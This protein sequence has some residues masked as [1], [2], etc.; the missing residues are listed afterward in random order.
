MEELV[1][2]ELSP[3]Q[4]RFWSLQRRTGH[5]FAQ[6]AL[7]VQGKPDC[8]LLSEA[9]RRAVNQDAIFR[10]AYVSIS[11]TE[12]PLQSINE[13]AVVELLECEL[14]SPAELDA[15][16]QPW[17]RV[18]LDSRGGP[19]L[20]VV[21]ASLADGQTALFLSTPSVCADLRSLGV[22]AARIAEHYKALSAGEGRPAFDNLPYLQFSEWQNR[23]IESEDGEEGKSYWLT[24]QVESPGAP[25]L[26]FDLDPNYVA[27][28]KPA[29][30]E[31]RLEGARVEQL[32]GA[33]RATESTVEEFLALS[34]LVLLRH[35][36]GKA[37]LT[38]GHVN[39]FRDFEELDDT[40][41]LLSRCLP[42]TVPLSGQSSFRECLSLYRRSLDEREE[43]KFFLPP[44]D[45]LPQKEARGSLYYA[46]ECADGEPRY[47]AA[48]VTFIP[49][50]RRSLTETH[51]L[52]LCCLTYPERIACE[53]QYHEPSFSRDAVD[54]LARA[55]RSVLAQCCAD[56]DAA[57]DDLEL[58]DEHYTHRLLHVFNDT[59]R[60]FA[61]GH[62]TVG[63][64]FEDQAASFPER[65]ALVCS[66]RSFAYRELNER[67][68]GLAAYL[69]ER[70]G[71][72][73]GDLL[74]LM[75][76]E[77]ERLVIGMLGIIKA[78]GAYVPLD[79]NNPGERIGLIIEDSRAKVI[80]TESDLRP[81]LAGYEGEVVALDEAEF[82]PRPKSGEAFAGTPN[83]TSYVIYTSGTTGRPKGVLI[84][85]RSLVNYACWLRHTFSFGPADSSVL[86]SSYA[87]D[88]G[89]TSIW[90]MLL[91]GGCLHLVPADMLRD[92]DAMVSYLIDQEVSFVKTTPS[93]FHLLLQAARADE[94]GASGLR[95]VLL[96]G[97]AIRVKDLVSFNRL[98]PG[99]TLVNHYGPTEATIG[100][101]AHVIDATRL[102][103][104]EN[105]PVIGRPIANSA[106]Y[107]LGSDNRPVAPGV[108]GELCVAGVGLAKGYRR[109]DELSREKFVDNPFV[110]G[111]KMYRTGDMARWMPEGTILYLGRLDGQVK[112][113]GYRVE[114]S[115]I[116]SALRKHAA[117]REAVAVALE[118][119][120]GES[121]LLAYV[122][123]GDG[124]APT[125]SELRSHLRESLPEYMIPSQFVRIKAL[126]LTPNGKVDRANLPPA[127]SGEAS[128]LSDLSQYVAPTNEVETRLAEA[129]QAILGVER[130]GIHDN[131]FELGGDSIKAIRIATRLRRERLE[132]K[133]RDLFRH[134]TVASLAAHVE[135]LGGTGARTSATGRIPLTP[136]QREHLSDVSPAHLGRHNR[137][138]LLYAERR[139]DSEA[140]GAVFAA[141]MQHHDLLRAELEVGPPALNVREAHATSP[142]AEVDLRDAAD[143][144][145]QL[146]ERCA[147]LSAEIDLER[148]PLV[149]LS[150]LRLPDRDSLLIV[151]PDFI[152]DDASWRILLADI[153]ALYQ[154][155]IE[156]EPLTL[157]DKTAAF[158]AWA[159]R[160]YGNS[161]FAADAAYWT[162]VEAAR[163]PALERDWDEAAG[164]SSGGATL[165]FTLNE[166]ET[167]VLLT[168]ANRAFGTQPADLLVAALGMA[169]SA[170][171][172]LRQLKVALQSENRVAVFPDLDTGRTV[173]CF[174]YSYPL[175]LDISYGDDLSRQIKVVKEALRDVP[176]EGLGYGPLRHA[177]DAARAH[178]REAR[179]QIGFSYANR[180]AAQ[181]RYSSFSV[182]P[183]PFGLPGGLN[184]AR[185]YE[186]TI[187]SE[188]CDA[189][190]TVAIGFNEKQHSHEKVGALLE[191][192][193]STLL[194]IL[195]YCSGRETTEL[196]P[197][198][199]SYKGLSLDAMDDLFDLGQS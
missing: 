36:T 177:P 186:L 5:L 102:D 95:L 52:K 107:I 179:P 81:Y 187:A 110:P 173:G 34:W 13:E 109:A 196:T 50:F 43:Q 142:L 90:G 120:S 66:G 143:P 164:T 170:G 73:A 138:A 111:T 54:F 113:S 119:D 116:E 148:G 194:N 3:Q 27:E 123:V 15:P 192:Y 76:R 21:L 65:T 28:F 32:R 135:P 163:A 180:S 59:R 8:G 85:D 2:Y 71:V 124:A 168:R 18:T 26:P 35:L 139:F 46:F 158:K 74:G 70:M 182:A 48:G 89:Y 146:A 152:A 53:F 75:C 155:S 10:T 157:P 78:G 199:F 105:H 166:E 25:A 128:I 88:L 160:L 80:V 137:A 63:E 42:L 104:Y 45:L 184:G 84:R 82:P 6:T 167:D 112:V 29:F 114:L 197:S 126:P 91:S 37:S 83:D 44:D 98:A 169:I 154:K 195:N 38:V 191:R 188:V 31:L 129:W 190:L 171:H 60:S 69:R 131:F 165:S 94:L 92:P 121:R 178:E 132:L 149:K 62:K 159:E 175:A 141:I 58:L 117:V 176:H 67:A 174:T 151:I 40:L 99:V 14:D 193:H 20:R 24:H 49:L 33:L 185:H 64:L 9:T 7:L 145:R 144:Q 77:N 125:G 39:S 86:M 153:D 172:G 93:L 30:F 147:S 130:V 12:F 106:A 11:E 1:G 189:R 101:V 161:I 97:E 198:D 68:E 150:L 183:E 61:D 57:L 115:E 41:G 162:V 51:K 156:G 134:P 56:P 4:K 181:A 79:P 19:L 122:V 17:L 100:T 47:E 23:L 133:V 96:G 87:F 140:L 108:A 16:H 72:E 103:A 22:L 118:S 55:F 127:N 136:F